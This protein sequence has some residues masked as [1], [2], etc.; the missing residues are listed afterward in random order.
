MMCGRPASAPK[1]SWQGMV[2]RRTVLARVGFSLDQV[3]PKV[4]AVVGVDDI[5]DAAAAAWSATRILAGSGRPLPDPP[6]VDQSGRQI[7]IWA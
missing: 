3:D 1:K 7:A 2:E 5:I 6:E 4:G